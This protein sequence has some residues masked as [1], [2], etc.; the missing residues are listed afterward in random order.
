MSRVWRL[1]PRSDCKAAASKL[2]PAARLVHSAISNLTGQASLG[3]KADWCTTKDGQQN[4]YGF[5][6]CG[7]KMQEESRFAQTSFV[8]LAEKLEKHGL[9]E[10]KK[11]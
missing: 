9:V 2:G 8:E 10:S 11:K 3:R 7:K 5:A 1:V 6:V 4:I